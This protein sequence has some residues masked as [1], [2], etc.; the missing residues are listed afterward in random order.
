MFLQCPWGRDVDSLNDLQPCL[1]L[2]FHFLSLIHLHLCSNHRKD[3][4]KLTKLESLNTE[5]CLNGFF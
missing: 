1:L 4:L 3:I 5:F 2:L